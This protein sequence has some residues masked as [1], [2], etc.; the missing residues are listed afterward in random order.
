MTKTSDGFKTLFSRYSAADACSGDSGVVTR[1]GGNVH[2]GVGDRDS[3]PCGGRDRESEINEDQ[4]TARTQRTKHTHTFLATTQKRERQRTG[5]PET[6]KIS[7]GSC[8]WAPIQ[9]SVETVA[10]LVTAETQQIVISR[11][12]GKCIKKCTYPTHG[13]VDIQIILFYVFRTK[14]TGDVN[15]L[16]GE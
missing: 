4:H 5:D 6:R 13:T 1:V 8:G 9:T 14:S 11:G 10:R 2:R 12:G 3:V 15:N 16:H 7:S